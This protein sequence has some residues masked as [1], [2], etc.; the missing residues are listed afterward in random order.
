MDEK[1]QIEEMAKDLQDCIDYDEWAARE[2]GETYVDYD[3]TAFNMVKLGYRKQSGWIS[4]DER[5]PSEDERRDEFE[6]L[7]PFL[8]CEKDTK[9]PYR[10]FY[11]GTTWGDGL[12]KI[13]GITHWMPLPEPPVMKGGE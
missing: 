1:K 3:S 8:V 11:D 12:M 9:H 10:A 13:K 5:L 7:V 4:V 2:Y 6:E